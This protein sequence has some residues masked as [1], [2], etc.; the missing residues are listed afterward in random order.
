MSVDVGRVRT[1]LAQVPT[2]VL[3]GLGVIAPLATLTWAARTGV[4]GSIDSTVP[5]GQRLV[6]TGWVTL[7]QAGASTVATLAVG[8]PIAVVLARFRFPGRS[9]LLSLIHISEPTRPY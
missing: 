8:L 6:R 1:T 3:L 2:W 5:I 9:V 7:V 4:P